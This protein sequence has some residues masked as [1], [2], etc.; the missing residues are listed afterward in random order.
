MNQ[1]GTTRLFEA[2]QI[3]IISTVTV[4]SLIYAKGFLVPVVLAVF[5]TM[6]LS[7]LR[8]A[9]WNSALGQRLG[10]KLSTLAAAMIL[11]GFSSIVLTTLSGQLSAF[12]A[13]IPVYE[14]NL[15]VL[16]SSLLAFTHLDDIPNVSSV[17][18]QVDIGGFL[19]WIGESLS[20]VAS[21]VFLT[22]LYTLFLV[23]EKGNIPLKLAKLKR[24]PSQALK[25]TRLCE[26]IA[27]RVQRY[28]VMKSLISLLTAITSYLV[29]YIV[30]VDFSPLWALIIFFLN[31]IPNIGSLF[32]V[33]LPSLLTVLQFD[34]LTPFVVVCFGLSIIQFSIGN[35]MEP[36][37]LGRQLN[38]SSF[39]VLLSLSFWGA[40]W[41]LVGMF[42][43]V[44]LLVITSLV[45]QHTKRLYW[46]SVLLSVDGHIAEPL[47]TSR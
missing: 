31:F 17:M 28:I 12:K 9:V 6:L 44:P 30:G 26:D 10:K 13:A 43:S 41:G 20:L 21:N 11:F 18:R 3:A 15:N 42:L 39:V 46:V 40:I 19:T 35:I 16:L 33:L 4:L 7:S 29:L 36:A 27:H 8:N 32:G 23:S 38:L 2:T 25:V 47:G 14:S 1:T 5:L 34:T 22:F 45:C 24:E 37:Y